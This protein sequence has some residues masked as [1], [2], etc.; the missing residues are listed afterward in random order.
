MV[1]KK[2]ETGVGKECKGSD[3]EGLIDEA[4]HR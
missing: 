1:L 4:K 3:D 2:E